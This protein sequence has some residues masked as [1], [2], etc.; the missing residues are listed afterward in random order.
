MNAGITPAVLFESHQEKLGLA[1]VAGSAGAQR[2]LLGDQPPPRGSPFVGWVDYLSLINPSRIQIF[3]PEEMR[4]LDGLTAQALV[5]TLQQIFAREPACLIVSDGQPIPDRLVSMAEA[6]GT[7]LLKSN[8]PG[9]TLIGY[10]RHYLTDAFAERVTVHGVFLS[11]LDIG[12]LLTGRSGIGKSELALEL[13]SRH[14]KLIADDSP[15]FRRISPTVLRGFCSPSDLSGYLEVRGLGVLDIRAMFG[16]SA[17]KL[18]KNLRL[19]IDL[20]RMDD[21]ELERIDRLHG[22]QHHRTLL[23]VD[24]PQITLPVMSGR[25]LAVMVE[26]AVS[27]HILMSKG[28]HA[29]REFIKQHQR[30]IAGD[31]T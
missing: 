31:P 7:P 28:R 9:Y 19:I 4:Y 24:I 26:S 3:G 10:L 8:L 13:L 25:N 22:S 20:K 5:E 29:A 16:D 2:P 11:V 18:S 6:T 15:E 30:L 14:H 23:D 27:N 12:V 17:I 1:W 21:Q